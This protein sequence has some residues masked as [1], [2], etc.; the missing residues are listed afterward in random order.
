M[1]L[2]SLLVAFWGPGLTKIEVS[3]TRFP[4]HCSKLSNEIPLKITK[5]NLNIAISPS[6]TP[7]TH[8]PSPKETRVP[9]PINPFETSRVLLSTI[10][11]AIL[12]PSQ[13]SIHDQK[14]TSKQVHQQQKAR[15]MTRQRLQSQGEELPSR[16][17]GSSIK[18]RRAHRENNCTAHGNDLL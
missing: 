10:L 8:T 7:T 11:N 3:S 18:W 5:T 1:K 17:L 13:T 15:D 9:D 12:T 14:S 6:T 4:A 16:S 2:S